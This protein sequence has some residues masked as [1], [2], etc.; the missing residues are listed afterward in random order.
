METTILKD[1]SLFVWIHRKRGLVTD[2]E[3]VQ[4]I[5]YNVTSINKYRQRN[6]QTYEDLLS[7]DRKVVN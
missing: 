5:Y 6:D 1:L 3:F 7:I 2:K 4:K